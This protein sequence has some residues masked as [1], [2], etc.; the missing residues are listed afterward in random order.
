[1]FMFARPILMISFAAGLASAAFADSFTFSSIDVPGATKTYAIGINASGQIVGGYVDVTGTE[2]GFLYKS[3]KFSTIDAP[4]SS[5]R[6]DARGINNFGH[7]V[8]DYT[9]SGEDHGFLDIF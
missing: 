5:G 9:E 1:M 6:T 8:G 4:G 7:I 3:G 2:H